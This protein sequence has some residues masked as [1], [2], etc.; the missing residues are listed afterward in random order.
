MENFYKTSIGCAKALKSVGFALL[1][2]MFLSV[3]VGAVYAQ[4]ASS[5]TGKR[6]ITGTVT[7]VDGS[8][9][10]GATVYIKDPNV[11]TTTP[12]AGLFVIEVL[13]K[14]EISVS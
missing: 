1:L 8:P 12:T 9:L 7:D 10:V 5:Q 11:G 6:R 14:Q 2:V 4:G 13:P 3:N